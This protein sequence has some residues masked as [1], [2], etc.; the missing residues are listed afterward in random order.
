MKP[1]SAFDLFAKSKDIGG[2]SFGV[3][4]LDTMIDPLVPSGVIEISGEAGCGK[5]QICLT[6]ALRC[7]LPHDLG[8]MEGTTAYMSCGEGDFPVRRLSQ[9]ANAMNSQLVSEYNLPPGS[10]PIMLGKVLIEQVD[11]FEHLKESLVC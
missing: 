11:H 4:S 5:S 2:L 8:G 10:A 6:L 3:P 1:V 9:M 7:Q